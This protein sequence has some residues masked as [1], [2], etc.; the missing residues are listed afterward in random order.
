M[1]TRGAWKRSTR[2]TYQQIVENHLIPAL[3]SLQMKD[4]TVDRIER[5]LAAKARDGLSPGTRNRH[6]NMLSL[7]MRAA[8]RRGL[9]PS[10][11]VP[12]IDRP[13][14]RRGKWRILSPA[15]VEAI[16]QAFEELAQAAAANHD[17]LL[18]A[19]LIVA[20]RLFVVHLATGMRRGEAAGLR[21]R[22]VFLADPEGAFLRVE[23]TW[24]RHAPDTPKS[25]AG[26]RT[27]D[28]GERVADELF[29]HRLW[30]AFNGDDDLVFANPRTG[31]PFDANRY[32]GLMRKAL[33]RV[34]ITERLRPS[35]DL[36]HSSITNAARAGTIPEALM[37]RAGHS[38]YATTRRY[39][40]LAGARFGDEANRLERRLWGGSSTK[41]RYQKPCERGALPVELRKNPHK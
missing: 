13:R 16:E 27:I 18:E 28:L 31:K 5:Y 32:S 39:I 4:V 20:R 25:E 22:R 36:R 26:R 37:S 17:L 9:I 6:L 30:S 2:K 3:G 15:E 29:E 23:E 11:P 34:G 41:D 1:P 7:A 19:D 21:W 10:N 33:N 24:V 40:D 14:E 38:S 8:V 35:H 12:L